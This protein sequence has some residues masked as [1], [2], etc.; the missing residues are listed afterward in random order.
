MKKVFSIVLLF[1]FVFSFT[2]GASVNAA[3]LGDLDTLTVSLN[4]NTVHPDE[5]VTITF[6]FGVDLGAYTFY[7]DFDDSLFEYV[8]A[9]NVTTASASGDIVTAYFFDS[10]GGSSPNSSMTVTF[11]AKSGITTSNPTQFSITADGLASPTGADTYSDITMPIVKDI[12]VEP[13]YENYTISISH[14]P[15][16]LKNEETPIIVTISSAMGRY[17]DHL[18][19]L[20]EVTTPNG[21]TMQLLRNR[22]K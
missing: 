15:T 2:L 14:N 18:R 16:I 7:I 21:A 4:K 10:T 5:T 20:A 9:T 3:D 6:N 11:K 8:S 12:L 22:F 17:Y 13:A 19:L 1:A